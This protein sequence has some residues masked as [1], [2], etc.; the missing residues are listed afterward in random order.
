MLGNACAR[1]HHGKRAERGVG[2]GSGSAT[3]QTAIKS[4]DHGFDVHARK[5]AGHNGTDHQRQHDRYAHQ[6]QNH[7]HGY[8]NHN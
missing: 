3:A 4:I 8:G 5:Q 1:Q 7:N 2:Q 6:T